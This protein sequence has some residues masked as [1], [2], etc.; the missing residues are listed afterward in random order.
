MTTFFTHTF[1][2][3][4][5]S[6]LY[7]WSMFGMCIPFYIGSISTNSCTKKSLLSSKTVWICYNENRERGRYLHQRI[8]FKGN[9]RPEA[10]G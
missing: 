5:T 4:G 10:V 6:I 9:K 1:C 3:R 8:E 2:M 7:L